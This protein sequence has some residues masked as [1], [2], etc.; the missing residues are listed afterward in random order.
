MEHD[1]SANSTLQN[2]MRV[3]W[4]RPG[5]PAQEPDVA[6]LS[7]LHP[8]AGLNAGLTTHLR[9]RRFFAGPSTSRPEPCP[10][11][12]RPSSGL[13]PDHD[14]LHRDPAARRFSVPRYEEGYCL[15]DNAR[16]LLLMSRLERAG[17]PPDL[18]GLASRYLAFVS[19]AFNAPLGRFRNF[20]DFP[21]V[22]GAPGFRGQPRPGPVG[23]GGHRRRDP[24]SGSPGPGGGTVPGGAAGSPGV[25]RPRPWAYALLGAHAYLAAVPGDA[26]A[27][28]L[29]EDL[30]G[31]LHALYRERAGP[32]WPWFED[33]L[34]YANARLPQALILAGGRSRRPDWA[35]AGLDALDW[36]A[37]V[38]T[39]A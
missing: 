3:R 1:E 18:A 23:P 6:G 15:D 29:E 28:A 34:T 33:R 21:A 4:R 38:Q 2:H 36:L 27:A 24:G 16:A 35:A 39:D 10:R 20:M 26:A 17:P 31:R 8:A 25:P 7:P 12:R 14:R 13:P 32:S 37:R 11:P 30:A 9:A 22:A 5:L 19:H